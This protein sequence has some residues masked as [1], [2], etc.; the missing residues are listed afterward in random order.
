MGLFRRK[1]RGRHALGAAV[2][3]LPSAPVAPA[4]AAPPPPVAVEPVGEPDLLTSIAQLIA[5]G[6]AWNEPVPAAV[7]PA[8]GFAASSAAPPQSALSVFD[9]AAAVSSVDVPEVPPPAALLG[10]AAGAAQADDAASPADAAEVP[11]PMS[12]PGST[13]GAAPAEAAEVAP[14]SWLGGAAAAAPA[15]A[16]EAPPPVSLLG[17]TAAAAQA[18]PATDDRLSSDADELPALLSGGPLS[19]PAPEPNPP[20]LRNVPPYET[21]RGEASLTGTAPALAVSAEGVVRP[22]PAQASLPPVPDLTAL[23]T[24]LLHAELEL[25]AQ[26]DQAP[27]PPAGPVPAPAPAGSTPL[28][29]VS[30]GF[31][32]PVQAGPRVEL[33]F[34]DGTT[35]SLDPD[36]E[37]A[38]A[39]AEV[40]QMLNARD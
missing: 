23:D 16:A 19:R 17:A 8:P 34:R 37:Q 29:A 15:D 30:Q 27:P 10:A 2:T 13:A 7:V 26:L 22:E 35:A 40:S 9:G 38:L 32:V 1:P 6:E 20:V 24:A 33:G 4:P 39:L 25:Q 12:F 36:S 3:S 31:A 11:P 21:L 18:D 5:S 28:A 14:V